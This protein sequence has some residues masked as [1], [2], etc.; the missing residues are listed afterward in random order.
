MERIRVVRAPVVDGEILPGPVEQ[1][2][3]MEDADEPFRIAFPLRGERDVFR[4]HPGEV[5]VRPVF[6]DVSPKGEQRED[7]IGPEFFPKFPGLRMPEESDLDSN[8]FVH[9]SAPFFSGAWSLC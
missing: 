4:V 7:A 5:A 1:S 8:V 6:R 9:F 3:G 2:K